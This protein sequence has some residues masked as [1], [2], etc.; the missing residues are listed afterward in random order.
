MN[1]S[2]HGKGMT[3]IEI[4]FAC[5]FLITLLLI[6]TSIFERNLGNYRKVTEA[7]QKREQ[8]RFA[9]EAMLTEVRACADL[10][11]PALNETKDSMQFQRPGGAALR[12]GELVTY[13]YDAA[14]RSLVRS[15]T[16]SGTVIILT[17][18][19]SFSVQRLDK[20]RVEIQIAITGI[21][22][23]GGSTDF[24][25][26]SMATIRV[27]TIEYGSVSCPTDLGSIT[28]LMPGGSELGG[29]R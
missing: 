18:V 23:G 21:V 1:K 26:C 4:L 17:D 13:S 2:W 22:T 27:Y 6:V 16:T 5:T 3:L 7:N 8:C 9:M 28:H 14:A 20:A 25:L 10:T 19:D 11:V 15:S 12:G 24:S 29:L